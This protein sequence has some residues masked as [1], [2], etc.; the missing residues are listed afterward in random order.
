VAAAWSSPSASRWRRC[1]PRS[2]IAKKPEYKGKTLFDV[3][4]RNGK[5]EQVPAG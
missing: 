5:V 3:L 1:G 2:C 4:Y